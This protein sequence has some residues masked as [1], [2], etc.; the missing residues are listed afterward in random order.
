MQALILTEDGSYLD[1]DQRIIFFSKERYINQIINTDNCF[2]CG[3]SEQE[4]K[5]N[6]EHIIPKWILK[7]YEL[8]NSAITLYNNTTIKYNKYVVKCCAECNTAMGKIFEENL[9]KL[10]ENNYENFVKEISNK[11]ALKQKI[12]IWIALIYFKMH[13]KDTK[14]TSFK[15]TR[16]SD[17]KLG[18]NYDWIEFHH[19]HC[20][21][22]SFYTNAI[23]E[24]KV[25]GSIMILKA[26]L[27]GRVDNFDLIDNAEAKTIAI[28]LGEIIILAVLNDS[29]ATN[30]IFLNDFEKLNLSVCSDYQLRELFSHYSYINNALKFRP[31]YFSKFENNNYK[32][33]V[34]MPERLELLRS[35][36]VPVSQGMIFRHLIER[37]VEDIPNK[38]EYLKEIENNERTY[39]LGV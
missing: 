19:I 21:I 13:Y 15:D 10:F 33:Y 14:L 39:L 8:Y 22:R 30:S 17:E 4:K 28:Q 7:R 23:I 24:D 11:P 35:E 9:S 2:I 20:L 25:F 36:E 27:K 12:F 31:Q 18:D 16:K 29:K 34:K 37:L 38:E 32:I 1:L 3:S 26:D 6:D 5:F